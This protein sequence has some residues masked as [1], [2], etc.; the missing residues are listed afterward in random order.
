MLP[1]IRLSMD[2]DNPRSVHRW[3]LIWD[4]HVEDTRCMRCRIAGDVDCVKTSV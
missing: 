3:R 4:S 2:T 1:K